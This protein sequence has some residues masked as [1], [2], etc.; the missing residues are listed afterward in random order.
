MSENTEFSEEIRERRLAQRRAER[1]RQRAKRR[2]IR[3][4]KHFFSLG[5]CVVLTV[6][7]LVVV[8]VVGKNFLESQDEKN[9]ELA[10]KVEQA[11]QRPKENEIVTDTEPRMMDVGEAKFLEG[12]EA[13]ADE[14]TVTM[15][16]EGGEM[17]SEFAI[18]IDMSKNQ[19]VAQKN[20]DV[21]MNPAS[22]TKILTILVASE[23]VANLDERLEITADV[24]DYAFRN[25]CSVV[26]FEIG[27]TPTIRDLFYGTILPSGADAAVSLACYVAGSQDAF[28]EMMN[29]KVKELG[30]S[31][32]AHFTNCVGLYDEA[33]QCTVYDMAMILK[34]AVE[35]RWCRA[36]LSAHTYTT[37]ATEQ[38]PEGLTISNWFL[39]RIEDRDTGG[40]VICA[41]TGFVNESGSCAASYQLSES[42]TPY[43]CVTGKSGSSWRCI[44]DQVTIYKK[45]AK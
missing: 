20:A 13:A 41:K 32:T 16:D 17:H 45:Y 6:A 31:E 12:F 8:T 40:T 27:E 5:F 29:D 30:L 36:V 34:A 2:V 37:S 35:N 14:N 11:A 24:T 21:I 7:A 26:G 33:H 25:E 42:G 9:E 15:G 28:V 3:R 22:M 18:L 44:Y 43:I 23:H 39:R 10:Q 1:S 38:H 4:I 19:I